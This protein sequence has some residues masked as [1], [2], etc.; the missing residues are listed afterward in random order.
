[1]LTFAPL[2]HNAPINQGSCRTDSVTYCLLHTDLRKDY[3]N[4]A[5]ISAEQPGSRAPS[6]FPFADVDSCWPQYPER[7]PRARSQEAVGL[8]VQD[9]AMTPYSVIRK[10]ADF[11]AAN[12]G[13]RFATPGFVLLVQDRRD[14]NPAIRLGI[15]ITKKVGNAVIRNRMRRRFRELARELLGKHGKSGADHILIGRGDGIERDFETL[16][17]EMKKAL[18]K[19]AEKNRSAEPVE[20]RP[21]DKRP[22]TGSGLR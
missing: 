22:S 16:R 2:D 11:L 3:S 1:M 9:T 8:I 7:T 19:L 20:T 14:D 5:H 18:I 13:R 12:R 15:T 17:S 21:A 6:R 10:R 4:E